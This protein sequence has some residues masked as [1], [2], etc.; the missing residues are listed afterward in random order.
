[1]RHGLGSCALAVALASEACA[2]A[3]AVATPGQV[4][5]A[6]VA[7]EVEPLCGTSAD[8]QV[9]SSSRGTGTVVV[10]V[11]DPEGTPIPGAPVQ[12]G[13]GGAVVKTVETNA[14]GVAL[15]SPSRTETVTVFVAVPG[16]RSAKAEGLRTQSNCLTAVSFALPLV[17]PICDVTVSG[18]RR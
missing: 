10:T 4:A 13:A 2:H 5:P 9:G 8:Q 16:F 17:Y 12:F 14:H 18:E 6:V 15:F 11:L 1:M 3:P 7:R